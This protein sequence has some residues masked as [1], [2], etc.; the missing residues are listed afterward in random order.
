MSVQQV[1]EE[2]AKL[3]PGEVKQVAAWLTSRFPQTTGR[4]RFA[5]AETTPVKCSPDAF[6]PLTD[7]ELEEF[8]IS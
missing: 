1:E 5:D 3:T 8:G 6:A 4:P 7:A 2:I